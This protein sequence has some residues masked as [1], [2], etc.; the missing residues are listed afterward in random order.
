MGI[1]TSVEEDPIQHTSRWIREF[2]AGVVDHP[3]RISIHTVEAGQ[4]VVYVLQVHDTDRAQLSQHRDHPLQCLD[5]LLRLIGIRRA[6]RYQLLVDGDT[7]VTT[8]GDEEP[9]QQSSPRGVLERGFQRGHFRV[10]HG[11]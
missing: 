8:T 3:S 9:A 6:R 11:D 1:Q 10:L 2:V 5:T 4:L 7:H